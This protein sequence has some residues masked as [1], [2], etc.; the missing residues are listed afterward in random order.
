MGVYIWFVIISLICILFFYVCYEVDIFG[1]NF[2]LIKILLFVVEVINEYSLLF[3]IMI[4]LRNVCCIV[5]ID[6]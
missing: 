4:I 3:L 5:C 6:F 2:V 1:I